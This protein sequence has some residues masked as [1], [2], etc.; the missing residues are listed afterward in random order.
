MDLILREYK[1]VVKGEA[2]GEG[3]DKKKAIH[4]SN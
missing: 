4:Y 3:A 2:I 1:K